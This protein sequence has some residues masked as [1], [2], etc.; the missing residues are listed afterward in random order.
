MKLLLPKKPNIFTR[1]PFYLP[2]K[3]K[4]KIKRKRPEI[5][6]YKKKK[7]IEEE[8][9][10]NVKK[11]YRLIP[12]NDE[13]NTP[14]L[15]TIID[16]KFIEIKLENGS[17]YHGECPEKDV[18]TKGMIISN[19]SIIYGGEFLN[20]KF[21]GEGVYYIK[22]YKII[23][24]FKEGM[25]NGKCKIEKIGGEGEI[26]L[27][28]GNIKDFKKFGNGFEVYKTYGE[29]KTF[30]VR[31]K[32]FLWDYNNEYKKTYR[33]DFDNDK[34]NGSGLITYWSGNTLVSKFK[35]GIPIDNGLFQFSGGNIYK[36]EKYE[37]IFQGILYD[38]KGNSYK[39]KWE[40]VNKIFEFNICKK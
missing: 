28:E 26:E 9:T 16:E 13:Y 22:D 24:T 8:K 31:D 40:R 29:I 7:K 25:I 14:C 37:N 30:F 27:Y 6:K 21:D 19:G 17:I 38:D 20:L 36:Y 2:K 4:E 5:G 15:K 1:K 12:K 35:D 10:E 39:G 33:G 18:K 34:Y 23:S 32:T 3:Q 11:V